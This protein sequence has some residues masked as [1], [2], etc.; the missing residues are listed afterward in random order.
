VARTGSEK[1]VKEESGK[2]LCQPLSHALRVRILEVANERAISPVQFVN[3]ELQPKGIVF[4]SPQHPM[5]HVSYHFRELEKA[6]CLYVIETIQ[7]RGAI[8]HVYVGKVTLTTDEFEKLSKEER[9]DLSRV[10]L[11]GFIARADS[12]MWTDTFDK[13]KDRFLAWMPLAL[14]EQAWREVIQAL[15]VCF[16]TVRKIQIDAGDRLEENEDPPVP[17]TMALFGFESPPPTKPP[18]AP[19][20]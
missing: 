1:L 9:S 14:D 12:S 18:A 3:E 6:G 4:K 7:R 15:D 16:E 17:A 5:S 10:G 20:D 2:T 11:Q 8:E 13:R 19:E